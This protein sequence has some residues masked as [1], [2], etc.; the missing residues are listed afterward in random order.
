MSL[1]TKQF[2]EFAN[3]RLD[4][5]EKILLN[6]GK[7]VPLTPKVFDTLKVLLENAGRLLEKDE[8][9]NKIWQDRFVEE[10]NLTF[11]IKMLRKALG[12]DAAKPQF[13]ETVQRRGYRFIA[14]V[15][16]FQE[17][18]SSVAQ[19]EKADLPSQSRRPYFLITISII[20]LISL[21]SIAFVWL[22]GNKPFAPKQLS[23]ARLT[24][25]GKV[26]NAT[27][28]PDGKNIVF[29]QREGVGESLW[30]RQ[31][32]T[33][34]QTQILPPED[35][36][37]VGLTVSPDNS[38]AYYSVF[39]KN[40]AVS[41]LARISLQG[42]TPEHLPEIATDVSVSFSPDG[43]KFAFTDS[44]SSIKETQLK[45]A[46]AEGSNQRVLVTTKGENRVFP[47]FRASP[48]AWSPDGETIACV[49]QE[50]NE[51]SS[52]NKILLVNSDDGS[53]KYLSEKG[54]NFIEN[55]VWKDAE[56]LAFIEYNLSSSIKHI[57]QISRKTGE[58]RQLTNDLNDYEWLS[59][60]NGKV[61]TVQKN[62]FSSLHI[63]DFSENTNTLQPKQV[64]GESSVID[65]VA[66]S[67]DEKIF[68]NSWASGK[69]EIWQINPDG[70]TPQQLTTNS[71]L[72][73]S[74]AVSPIDNSLVFSTLQ[75]GKI[76][77]SFADSDGQNIRQMT[78]GTPDISPSFSP[79]GKTIVFQRGLAPPTLW[80]VTIEENQPPTQITGYLASHPTISP[81]GQTIA[82]HFMDYGGKNPHWKLGLINSENHRLLN[83]LEFPV[84]ITER[85]TAWHPNNKFLTMIFYNGENVGILLLSALDGKYQTLDNIGVGKIS[86][87]AW[88]PDGSR[89]AFSQNYETNDVVSLGEF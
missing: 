22:S 49:V 56:N 37:F 27:V 68:Y 9:M 13:I 7:P 74:F 43:K 69:N 38:Y 65:N 47:V 89:F 40:I 58:I 83:K 28:S 80:Q 33:G 41:N 19:N 52:F 57:W 35:V 51:N 18:V 62:V 16:E 44:Q 6:D 64:F 8:L 48:V 60:A 42:G 85:K 12:D 5:S 29:A 86:S 53:E 24:N 17:T 32:D 10:G 26:T 23:F 11:N 4:L 70:T 72:T 55:I 21:F 54:W 82:Y 46:D 34:I 31:I 30:V 59:S 88:S 1:Q 75:D 77:L 14:E 66:W 76:S 67:K 25:T 73:F 15:K 79:D 3:F 50:T 2:Y 39:S 87:F 84:P 78:N 36:K 81:D 61:F 71:N 45:T 20:S 63:A